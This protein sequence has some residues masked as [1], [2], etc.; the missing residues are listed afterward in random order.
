MQ[1]QIVELPASLVRH[2]K[3]LTGE[4]SASAAIIAALHEPDEKTKAHRVE[5]ARGSTVARGGKQAANFMRKF[6]G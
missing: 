5:H 3:K 1:T 2:V 6:L 4:R